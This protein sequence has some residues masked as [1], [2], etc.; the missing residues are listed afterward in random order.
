MTEYYRGLHTYPTKM[1]F[2][3]IILYY[4]MSSTEENK[5]TQPASKWKDRDYLRAYYREY[6]RKR[7][8]LKTH[9]YKM[10]DG[11]KWSEVHEYPPEFAS[12]EAWHEFRRER[13]RGYKRAEAEVIY[14]P[15]PKKK[16]SLCEV[17]IKA[18]KWE[19]HLASI[20]HK[21]MEALLE[22]HGVPVSVEASFIL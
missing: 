22:K 18:G 10:D 2:K 12:K 17:E 4:K 3:K 15:K 5:N 8:G 21:K 11:R 9:P 14:V 20:K 1:R 19:G 16:C 13:Q 6:N 7:H